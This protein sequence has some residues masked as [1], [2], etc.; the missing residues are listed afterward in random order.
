MDVMDLRGLNPAPVTLFKA[1]GSV[2]FAANADLAR[3]L[4]RSGHR[5]A[6]DATIKRAG[7]AR[8]GYAVRRYPPLVGFDEP[9]LASARAVERAAN[10]RVD[11][12]A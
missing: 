12:G 3:D 11:A 5:L 6:I 10:L 9:T 4:H 8:N 1:D 2:D 7:D